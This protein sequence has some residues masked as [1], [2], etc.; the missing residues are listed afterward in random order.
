[1]YVLNKMVG[2]LLSPMA[3]TLMMVLVG[4]VCAWLGRRRTAVGVLLGAFAWQWIWGTSAWSRVIV[5][6]M[7]RAYPVVRAEDVPS[8]DAIVVLGG[9]MTSNPVYP[10]ADI[11][12]AGDRAWHAARLYRA[13]KAPMVIPTGAADLTSTV[14]LLEDLGVPRSAIRVE[15]RARNT[16]E[17]ARL[18][19]DMLKPAAGAAKPRILLVTSAQHMRRAMLMYGRYAPELEIIPAA[20]DYNVLVCTERPWKCSDFFPGAEYL[21]K[22]SAAAKE[23]VGYW[24]YRLLRR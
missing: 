5:L 9:G 6:P 20:T 16:E 12:E 10:Y 15:N 21:L 3:L 24:G 7:E 22:N 4:A 17:N 1:M 14:P 23:I 19:A 11:C 13:G 8:A 18:V 2:W